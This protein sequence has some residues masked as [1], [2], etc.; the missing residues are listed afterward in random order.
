MTQ[1]TE[2]RQ[3]L[4]ELKIYRA[5]IEAVLVQFKHQERGLVRDARSLTRADE[6][7]DYDDQAA[8]FEKHC[9]LALHGNLHQQ[10]KAEIRPM[11]RAMNLAYAFLRGVPLRAVEQDTHTRPKW[12]WVEE[13]VSR[14][15]GSEDHREIMQRLSHWIDEA[16]LPDS[17]A[18][19]PDYRDVGTI[20]LP[21]G[22]I[23]INR[24]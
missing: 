2:R 22:N 15:S 19:G 20:L 8:A 7:G 13:I 11:V 18:P 24:M 1:D 3:F 23:G 16:N 4:R 9:M 5:G 14:Y 10:R 12:V 17:V 21:L 6:F